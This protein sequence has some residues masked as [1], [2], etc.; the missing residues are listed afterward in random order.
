MGAPIN[1]SR[2]WKEMLDLCRL[3]AGEN[4]V[5]LN[6]QEPRSPYARKAVQAAE[7]V[8]ANV[9]NVEVAD[10]DALPTPVLAAIGRANLLLDLAF[11]HDERILTFLADGL[12]ILVAVEPPEILSRM[13][14]TQND[15]HRCVAGRERLS[16]ASSMRVVSD[17]GTDFTVSLG[18][19]RSSCPIRFRR[20]ARTM[21]SVAR[22][23]RLHVPQ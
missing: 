2:M 13:F 4:V 7:V 11:S 21:G 9:C 14:P 15:K 5:I 20:G 12:R 17:A 10:T 23:L 19:Y 1:L 3:R 8:A 6:R 16:A 18:E 22:C